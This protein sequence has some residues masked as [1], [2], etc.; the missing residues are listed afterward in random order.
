M[1]RVHKIQR[2]AIQVKLDSDIEQKDYR[3]FSYATIYSSADD[4]G[5]YF[6]PEEGD[7]IRLVFPHS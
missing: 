6:M 1:G 3:W 2:D 4:T 5:W 7:R